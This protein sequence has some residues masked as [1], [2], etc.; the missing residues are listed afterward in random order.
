MPS[1]VE[2][3]GRWRVKL[4]L[5]T[6]LGSVQVLLCFVLAL[7][8]HGVAEPIQQV[9]VCKLQRISGRIPLRV[10]SVSRRV[11]GHSG[12]AIRCR[13]HL[14]LPIAQTRGPSSLGLLLR[15]ARGL[16]K[17]GLEHLTLQALFTQ[18]NVV[19]RRRR[20]TAFRCLAG[21]WAGP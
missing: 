15:S 16:Y 9:A 19:H 21:S 1:F 4:S 3:L 7:F 8:G 18:R 10:R 12:L 6:A 14:K 17:E 2:K 11:G 5:Q 13:L 20:L